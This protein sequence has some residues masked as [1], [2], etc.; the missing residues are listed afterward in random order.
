MT[1]AA[2]TAAHMAAATEA[3]AVTAAATATTARVG[4]AA[5]RLEARRAVA[6]TVIIRFIMTL[7]FGQIAR[8][9]DARTSTSHAN[10]T[11]DE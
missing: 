11:S 8:R 7:L 4:R 10:E 2:K 5:S 3:A 1:S 9:R 6:N